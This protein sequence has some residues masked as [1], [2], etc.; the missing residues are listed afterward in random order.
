MADRDRRESLV[1]LDRSAGMGP[2]MFRLADRAMA[3]MRGHGHMPVGGTD[4]DTVPVVSW[5]TNEHTAME[6][7]SNLKLPFKLPNCTESAP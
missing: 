3:L 1:S 6:H 2:F 7:S 5:S 4:S